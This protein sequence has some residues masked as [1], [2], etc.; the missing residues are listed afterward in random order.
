M[1]DGTLTVVAKNQAIMEKVQEKVLFMALVSRIRRWTKQYN[2]FLAVSS[3][4]LVMLIIPT[5]Q[6]NNLLIA[7]R[8]RFAFSKLCAFLK[9]HYVLIKQKK[10]SIKILGGQFSILKMASVWEN[11]LSLKIQSSSKRQKGRKTILTLQNNN[12]SKSIEHDY[13]CLCFGNNKDMCFGVS[14]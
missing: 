14:T 7:L 9:L 2:A 13:Y 5:D 6:P 12:F 10:I 4:G 8:K 1:S 3:D 11:L